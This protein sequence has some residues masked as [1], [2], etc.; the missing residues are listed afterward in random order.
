VGFEHGG[1]ATAL[2]F[3]SIAVDQEDRGCRQ[4]AAG[5][6]N[7][8]LGEKPMASCQHRQLGTCLFGQIHHRMEGNR[9]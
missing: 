6:N 7:P 3:W 1:N 4:Q 9:D 8:T 5:H 2:G